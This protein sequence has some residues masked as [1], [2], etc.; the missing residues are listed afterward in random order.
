MLEH[1]TQYINWCFVS[2][3]ND[4]EAIKQ[5][6]ITKYRKMYQKVLNKNPQAEIQVNYGEISF[7][8]FLA[9]WC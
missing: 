3:E 9:L 1:A 7:L 6:K 2:R 8:N 4:L 5:Q